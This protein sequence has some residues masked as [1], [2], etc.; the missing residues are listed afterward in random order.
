MPY[1]LYEYYS[2]HTVVQSWITAS[3]VHGDSYGF[4]QSYVR[5]WCS[6]PL[7]E[8]RSGSPVRC[9]PEV[10]TE[11]MSLRRL[12]EKLIWH[13]MAV[14]SIYSLLS[15]IF[16]Y[17]PIISTTVFLSINYS[18]F[19]FLPNRSLKISLTTNATSK[20]RIKEC[21]SASITLHAL[22]VIFVH[23]FDPYMMRFPLL[24]FCRYH[25]INERTFDFLCV[26]EDCVRN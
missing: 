9:I 11:Y 18:M 5:A 23:L 14:I 7:G 12:W 2:K 1:S 19:N 21:I 15:V 8:S 17:F 25:Q 6:G 13:Y 22:Y 24:P 26:W 10:R 16:P 20:R 4:I 3:Y